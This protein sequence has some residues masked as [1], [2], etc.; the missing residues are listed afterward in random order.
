MT[1]PQPEFMAPERLPVGFTMTKP[2]GLHTHLAVCEAWT[3]PD[4]WEL[5]LIVD[6]QGLPVSTV[7][8]SGDEMKALIETWR[9]AL[10][11]TGWS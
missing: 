6:G 9:A 1:V 10:L 4:G 2:E 7:L 11:K 5:R 3:H 8:Q